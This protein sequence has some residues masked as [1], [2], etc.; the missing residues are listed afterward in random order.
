MLDGSVRG[1]TDEQANDPGDVCCPGSVGILSRSFGE[2]FKRRLV[3]RSRGSRIH[4]TRGRFFLFYC[5]VIF[6]EELQRIE[7]AVVVLTVFKLRCQLEVFLEVG[8]G[9]LEY[10]AACFWNRRARLFS[11]VAD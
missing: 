8:R 5:V 1:K 7:I 3:R 11:K 10:F 9:F 2:Y 6:S 4:I